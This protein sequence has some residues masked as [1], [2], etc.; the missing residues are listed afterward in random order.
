[1]YSS[2]SAHPQL[3]HRALAAVDLDYRRMQLHAGLA[4]DL[5]SILCH[6]IVEDRERAP[7]GCAASHRGSASEV[8]VNGSP[9]VEIQ[10]EHLFSSHS[11]VIV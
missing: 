1:M 5:D 7:I 8:V 6:T 11:S 9:V 2:S 3:S 4:N 10:P